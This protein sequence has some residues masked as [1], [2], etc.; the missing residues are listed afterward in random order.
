MVAQIKY[1][2]NCNPEVDP[3]RIKKILQKIT[4][5]KDENLLICV[6]GCSRMCLA[7]KIKP[8]HIKKVIHMFSKEIMKIEAVKEEINESL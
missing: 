3:K 2:G 1:C 8:D 6:N 5:D 7:K 4:F